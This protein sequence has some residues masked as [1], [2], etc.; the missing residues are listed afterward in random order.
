MCRRAVM[1]RRRGTAEPQKTSKA[2]VRLKDRSLHLISITVV[3]KLSGQHSASFQLRGIEERARESLRYD[4]G[5]VG[6][7]FPS[8]PPPPSN[9]RLGSHITFSNH[10]LHEI[11]RG[12]G[13]VLER[14]PREFVTPDRSPHAKKA[15]NQSITLE[16][17]KAVARAQQA[18]GRR[19]PPPS[20]TPAPIRSQPSPPQQSGAGTAPG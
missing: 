16:L 15:A 19:P 13:W 18:V 6:G 3:V 20:R 1:G 14:L 17:R 7:V 12:V 8:Q 10:N 5:I 11:L 9:L 4:L 2:V